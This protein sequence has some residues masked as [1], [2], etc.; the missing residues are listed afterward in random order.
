MNLEELAAGLAEE[1]RDYV[2]EVTDPILAHCKR[3]DALEQAIAAFTKSV[4]DLRSEIAA[5]PAGPKGDKGDPG[6]NGADAVV[7]E[8]RIV[9]RL[10]SII[11]PPEKGE[12]G[13]PGPQGDKGDPGDAGPQG[14]RGLD[15]SNGKDGRDADEDAIVQRVLEAIPKPVDGKDGLPG[16]KGADG[17]DG[18]DGRDGKE[19]PA[20][21]DALDIEILDAIE[22]GRSYAAGTFAKHRAGLWKAIRNTDPISGDASLG[23]AGWQL[24]FDGFLNPVVKS[25]EDLRTFTL[26]FERSGGSV[27]SFDFQLPVVIHKGI[28]KSG[29]QYARG[30][31]V[32]WDGSSWIALEDTNET[33]GTS[34]AWRMSVRK[35]RDAK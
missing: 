30:D 35:G 12:K 1:T 26:A 5:I 11:P 16:Q 18:R 23:K 3:I 8:D 21:R 14:E 13:D 27:A 19:G 10:A 31:C 2:K 20:G 29:T 28:F 25:S 15:G 6:E 9:A 34:K 33:P 32:T 7:D 22:E 17:T 24:V 4:Q